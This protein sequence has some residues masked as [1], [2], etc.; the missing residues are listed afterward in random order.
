MTKGWLRFPSGAQAP[1]DCEGQA[2]PIVVEEPD[3]IQLDNDT[4]TIQPPWLLAP[5]AFIY[6]QPRN[7]ERIEVHPFEP[8]RFLLGNDVVPR[9]VPFLLR[10]EGRWLARWFER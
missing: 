4:L 8:G 9:G 2:G 7:G 6:L 1:F 10:I 3:W 5:P